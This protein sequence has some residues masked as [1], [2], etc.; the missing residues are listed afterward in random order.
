[1]S[2]LRSGELIPLEKCIGSSV[3]AFYHMFLWQSGTNALPASGP[4][5]H[6]GDNSWCWCWK[7]TLYVM[8]SRSYVKLLHFV[9]LTSSLVGSSC[10]VKLFATI[11]KTWV[12]QNRVSIE[13]ANIT[14]SWLRSWALLPSIAEEAGVVVVTLVV[15]ADGHFPSMSPEIGFRHY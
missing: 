6:S 8:S 14:S 4:C 9:P 3:M 11:L 12:A 7:C 15:G 2:W 10:K 13:K 5:E 1:M